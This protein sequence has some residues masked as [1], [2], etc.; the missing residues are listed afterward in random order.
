MNRV[1]EHR[2]AKAMKERIR[3]LERRLSVAT[4]KQLLLLNRLID[5]QEEIDRLRAEL[6]QRPA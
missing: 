1:T 4:D 3:V 5:A 6:E 2:T